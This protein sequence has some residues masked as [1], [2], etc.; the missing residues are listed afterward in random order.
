MYRQTVWVI[1]SHTS[2]FFSEIYLQYFDHTKIL[3]VLIKKQTI[4]YFKYMYDILIT[5]KENLVNIQD[6]LTNL[7]SVVPI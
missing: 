2:S 3:D 5:F 7:I 6:V 1:S 4:C